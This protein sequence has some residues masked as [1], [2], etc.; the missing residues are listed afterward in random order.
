MASNIIIFLWM[1]KEGVDTEREYL[2]WG[3]NFSPFVNQGE[4]WRLFTSMFIHFGL[5]HIVMNMLAL[6]SLGPLV[7]MVLGFNKTLFVYLL[8][9]LS[10]SL[11]SVAFNPLAISAGASGAIF[12]LFGAFIALLLR[13]RLVSRVPGHKP[14]RSA[15]KVLALNVLISLLPQIDFAAHMGGLFM[16]FL[17]TLILVT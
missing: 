2:E 8:S 6:A 15:L 3:A 12:G 9:G 5:L 16:G 10:G 11:A 4:Y 14:L 17:L 7:E 13:R 1:W